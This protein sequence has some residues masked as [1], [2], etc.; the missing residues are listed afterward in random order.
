MNGR[1]KPDV[2]AWFD[3]DELELCPRCD[4]RTVVVTHTGA[5]ICTECGLLGFR[6]I[7]AATTAPP[8]PPAG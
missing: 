4:Q 5:A 6:T 1:E 2:R 3:D 7:A 8:D